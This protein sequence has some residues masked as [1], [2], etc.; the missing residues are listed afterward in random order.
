MTTSTTYPPWKNI[1][2][3]CELTNVQGFLQTD[4]HLRSMVRQ[5][6]FVL[7]QF[8]ARPDKDEVLDELKW[9]HY[10]VYWSALYAAQ[11]TEI[12]QKNYAEC[13]VCDGLTIFY[14]LGAA[15]AASNDPQA[16][17][18]DAWE[19][20]KAEHLLP[21]ELSAAGDYA[22]LSV[23]QTR[24]NL[25][26][27]R[28]AVTFNKGYLPDSLQTSRNPAAIVWLHLDLNSAM[29][30]EESLKYFYDKLDG[31]G[32]VLLDDYGWMGY[33]DT[34]RVVDRFFM[35]KSAT[36]LQLPTGQAIVFKRRDRPAL[37]P[38]QQTL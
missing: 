21:S 4:R 26:D 27:H 9:R 8:S 20:M 6:R 14:A 31:S 36:L 15:T 18:Y 3:G 1:W 35:N 23:E 34:K 5:G 17:L 19:G 30:T 24:K 38:V 16:Y 13:G 25:A 11:H 12:R 7:S 28:E 37:R 22:Y 10:V 33:T 2:P 32:V 29:P